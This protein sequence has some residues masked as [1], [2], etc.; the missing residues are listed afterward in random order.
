MTDGCAAPG[1]AVDP[2]EGMI[3]ADLAT[4][5]ERWPALSDE[6]KARVLEMVEGA[7]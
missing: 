2:D 7:R 6:L 4:I 3:D 1:A 5:M